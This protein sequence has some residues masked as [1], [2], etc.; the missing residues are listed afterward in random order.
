[1]WSYEEYLYQGGDRLM[2]DLFEDGYVDHAIF[3]PAYL[4]Q[5][6]ETGFGQSE[7]AFALTKAHPGKLT[8]NHNFDP[9]NGEEG[10]DQLRARMK[11]LEQMG[12]PAEALG[13]FEGLKGRMGELET[14]AAAG[15]AARVASKCA[16]MS[17]GDALGAAPAFADPSAA[18]RLTSSIVTTPSPPLACT[19]AMSTPSLRRLR[20]EV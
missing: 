19:R 14:R 15:A 18:A 6:Y 12:E 10:L 11:A 17:A 1:M 8:Y 3:Q 7:E 9:R 4:N 20:N 13:L 2:K 16:R 5:F